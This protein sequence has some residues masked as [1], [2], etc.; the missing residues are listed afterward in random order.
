[1]SDCRNIII[2]SQA[3]DRANPETRGL[4]DLAWVDDV[5]SLPQRIV[6]APEIE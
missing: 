6:E 5:P 2:D 1:V 3:S 4:A